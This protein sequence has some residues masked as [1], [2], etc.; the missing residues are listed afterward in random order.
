MYSLR[1]K[2]YTNYTQTLHYNYTQSP[3]KRRSKPYTASVQNY[4]RGGTQTIHSVFEREWNEWSESYVTFVTNVTNV[5]N[6]KQEMAIG[7]DTPRH[8]CKSP[9]KSN[10]FES[11]FSDST[12]T[13]LTYRNTFRL[14]ILP[15]RRIIF[16]CLPL[17][18]IRGRQIK[19]RGRQIFPGCA[20]KTPILKG[21]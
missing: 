1:R 8:S 18:K 15:T 17:I 5:T 11:F 10:N 3:T 2:L 12:L 6:V 4:T 16:L 21:K 7:G 20:P 9:K 19:I 14:P 13:F